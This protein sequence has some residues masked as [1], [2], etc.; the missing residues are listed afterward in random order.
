MPE[1]KHE[2]GRRLGAPSGSALERELLKKGWAQVDGEEPTPEAAAAKEPAPES[3]DE[4][5]DLKGLKRAELDAIAQGL[6]VE[7]VADIPNAPAVAEAIV[8]ARK[9]ADN[10]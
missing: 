9:V 10:G 7:N 5:A 1:F 2:S 3:V 4:N 8:E 6:G